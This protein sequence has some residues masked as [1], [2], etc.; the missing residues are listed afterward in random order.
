MRGI[1]MPRIHVTL[2]KVL[3]KADK[4]QKELAELTKIRPAAISELYNNQR[5]SLNREHIDKIIT[6]LNITDINELIT[7]V[8]D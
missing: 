5:K 3:K 2:D 4:S 7:I 6:A 1:K 8:N